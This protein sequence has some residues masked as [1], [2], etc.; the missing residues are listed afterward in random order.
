MLNLN[1]LSWLADILEVDYMSCL[2]GMGVGKDN[3][4]SAQNAALV[5]DLL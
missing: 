3:H 5:A 1:P 2:E 4:C